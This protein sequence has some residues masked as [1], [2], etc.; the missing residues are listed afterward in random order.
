LQISRRPPN[1]KTILWL[2]LQALAGQDVDVTIIY[3]DYRIL[4]FTTKVKPATTFGILMLDHFGD[5]FDKNPFH[6]DLDF[7]Y[8]YE[9]TIPGEG[10][11]I[12]PE[13]VRKTIA[14]HA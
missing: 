6:P 14:E 5:C 4:G 7:L 12:S 8:R 1:L 2:D 9:T 3:M 13:R 10:L 11:Q